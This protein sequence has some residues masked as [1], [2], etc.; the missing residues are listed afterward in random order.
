MTSPRAS[1]LLLGDP[2]RTPVCPHAQGRGFDTVAAQDRRGLSAVLVAMVH[3]LRENDADGRT[4][5]V[6]HL[7]RA[8]RIVGRGD[9]ERARPECGSNGGELIERVALVA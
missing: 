9:G 2:D 1:V 5:A 8:V 3:E 4:V 7:D 6:A